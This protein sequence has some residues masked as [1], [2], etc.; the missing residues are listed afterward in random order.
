MLSV[1]NVLVVLGLDGGYSTEFETK[2]F[3]GVRWRASKRLSNV[4]HIYDHSLNTITSA[5]NL[6]RMDIRMVFVIR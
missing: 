3:S 5:F 6:V 4:R 2:E 1:D